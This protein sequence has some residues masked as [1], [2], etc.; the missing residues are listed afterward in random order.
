[1]AQKGQGGFAQ[2]MKDFLD[3][4]I[5]AQAR[6]SSHPLS[7]KFEFDDVTDPIKTLLEEFREAVHRTLHVLG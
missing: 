6:Q 1:M 5:T 3:E 7:V 4:L 2:M